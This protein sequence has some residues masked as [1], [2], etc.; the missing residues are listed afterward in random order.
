[1][2]RTPYLTR[3]ALGRSAFERFVV[4]E[5]PFDV[6]DDQDEGLF[7]TN[8]DTTQEYDESGR[9]INPVSKENKESQIRAMN[10]VLEVV[11]V[12]ERKAKQQQA[13]P[14]PVVFNA[15]QWASMKSAE[16]DLGD[17]VFIVTEFVDT[18]LTWWI[19]VLRRRIQAG[20]VDC[21][22]PLTR[23]LQNEW[24]TFKTGSL[25]Q[26][27]HYLTAGLEMELLGNILAEFGTDPLRYGISCLRNKTRRLKI[28][29][30][31][32]AICYKIIEF[33]R[34]SGYL[35]IQLIFSPFTIT[36]VLRQFRI[37]TD[38][39]IPSYIRFLPWHD[40]SPYRWGWSPG[41]GLLPLRSR[42]LNIA[43]SP[44]ALC[45]VSY[46]AT[47]C[48]HDL[49]HAV[50]S[51]SPSPT[52][53][54][55]A[56]GA[57]QITSARDLSPITQ[58]VVKPLT[59]FRD[60]LLR[61]TG[62]SHT[63]YLE[64]WQEEPPAAMPSTV[65]QTITSRDL[66]ISLGA[67]AQEAEEATRGMNSAAAE[68]GQGS[69]AAAVPSQRTS[70][71]DSGV[72]D[73]GRRQSMRRRRRRSPTFR[74]TRLST[75]PADLLADRMKEMGWKMALLPLE[76]LF[77]RAIVAAFEAGPMESLIAELSGRPM[78]EDK[79]VAG[80]VM[81][82]VVSLGWRGLGSLMSKVG[83][84]FAMEA[85][86]DAVVWGGVWYYVQRTGKE[87]CFWGRT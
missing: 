9:P 21:S 4:P 1:M 82:G 24:A 27:Y 55:P 63:A 10:E 66:L 58:A 87:K 15:E 64:G 29:D 72:P 70:Y 2:G 85:A 84:C 14:A 75:L 60:F 22:F 59:S 8:Q 53:L 16:D 17:D 61:A 19:D 80:S 35:T 52:I 54:T 36:S 51:S 31:Q 71:H 65:S 33:L 49:A 83:L 43:L 48:L 50:Q 37:V 44:V 28:D 3:L 69:P 76:I 32:K 56:K 5:S 12:T 18:I 47:C 6:E 57:I 77:H 74:T 39:F 7:T 23:I 38:N 25:S 40:H 45:L 78:P 42:L 68:T 20:L 26:K 81:A 11:G 13:A 73:A 30:D 79:G 62:W 34:V 46:T 67:T 41:S 86:A